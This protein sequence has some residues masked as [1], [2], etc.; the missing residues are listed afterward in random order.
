[1]KVHEYADRD[2][3][4]LSALI[5][6]GEVDREAV[7]RAA[8]EAIER[9]NPALNAVIMEDFARAAETPP[10]HAPRSRLSD[11]PFLLKDVNLYSDT[12]PT[13][14]ASRFF[15]GA[16]SRPDSL[17]V[18]RWRE[19]GLRLLGKTNTPEFAADFVTE[20]A[21][22]GATYNP[23]N[24][25]VTVGGSSGGA[26]AAVASGMVPLAHATDLGGSIRI[27]AACCGVFGFKPTAGLNPTG[28]YFDEIASGLNSDHVISRSV[29]D[30]AASLDIT[31]GPSLPPRRSAGFLDALNEAVPR[32]RIGMTV[33]DP[34]GRRAGPN[35]VRAVEQA[36]RVCAAL[37]HEVEDYRFPAEAAAGAWFD[38]LWMVDVDRLVRTRAAEIGRPPDPGELEPLTVH[39]LE[40]VACMAADDYCQARSRMHQV[41]AALVRSMSGLDIVLTPT[42][43]QDPPPLGTLSFGAGYEAWSAEGYAFAPY[44]IPFNLSGQPAAS[45]PVA[46]SPEGLPVGVQIAALPGQDRLVLQLAHQLEQ[47]LPW[48]ENIRRLQAT[49]LAE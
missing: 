31:A 29:R 42:L 8:V 5:A 43:A 38:L 48:H 14:F 32:L 46:F 6:C 21:F 40:R 1:M 44:S 28:P 24:R 26:A 25:A 37:G 16:P 34:F 13:T 12:M 19:A 23:W 17:L 7:F 9:L 45:C 3:I 10:P 49:K 18:R 33:T 11:V 41:A 2:G 30:S 47:E 20:P 35:Q 36:A 39:A 4:G 27:P 22:Y 15:R